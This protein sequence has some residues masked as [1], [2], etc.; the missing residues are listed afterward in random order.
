MSSVQDLE[1]LSSLIDHVYHGATDASLWPDIV[2]HACD[3]L[4]APK[5]MLYTPLHGPEQGGVYFQHGLTDH[6]LELYKS[7]YQ[8]VDMWTQQ[9][10]RLDLFKEGNVVLGTDLVPHQT[11]VSSQW[12][13]E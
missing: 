9:A 13:L 6:F 1:R 5:G 10:V 11:L 3:W 4:G 7:R 8:S 12:Y 2:A